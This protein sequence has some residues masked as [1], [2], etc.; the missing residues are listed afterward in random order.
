VVGASPGARVTPNKADCS[1]G[2]LCL[3][4]EP[5]NALFK[6]IFEWS[7]QVPVRGLRPTKLIVL[8]VVFV[9]QL[10]LLYQFEH[11]LPLGKRVKP[12]LRAA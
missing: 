2:C 7:G 11:G 1:G 10:V 4:I 12:L 9:Y 5:F 6:N 3:S 8:G